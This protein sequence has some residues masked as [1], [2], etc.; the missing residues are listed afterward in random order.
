M[1]EPP[2]SMCRGPVLQNVVRAVEIERH[3]IVEHLFVGVGQVLALPRFSGVVNNYVKLA[4]SL[5]RPWLERIDDLVAI[6]D[7]YLKKMA[8]SSSTDCGGA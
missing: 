6:G 1:I 3:H 5:P 7:V 2:S 8:P 4:E